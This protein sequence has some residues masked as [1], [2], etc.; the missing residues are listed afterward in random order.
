MSITGTGKWGFDY[1]RA[2][3]EVESEKSIGGKGGKTTG[4]LGFRYYVMKDLKEAKGWMG[5]KAQVL[6]FIGKKATINGQECIIGRKSFTEFVTRIDQKKPGLKLKSLDTQHCIDKLREFQKSLPQVRVSE[7][8]GSKQSSKIHTQATELANTIRTSEDPV[9]QSS[10][11]LQTVSREIQNFGEHPD[12]EHA[13]RVENALDA[14]ESREPDAV[15]HVESSPEQ[16]VSEEGE[17]VSY[18]Q[19]AKRGQVQNS[20]IEKTQARIQLIRGNDKIDWSTPRT[21]LY[22]LKQALK[23]VKPEQMRQFDKDLT[24]LGYSA[25]KKK[26]G[27]TVVDITKLQAKPKNK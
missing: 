6:M 20:E 1:H 14:A 22:G 21:T 18:A 19:A 2:Y 8:D 7:T 13:A 10:A 27:I 11:A 12:D 4:E 26:D 25:K 3:S 9:V 24:A 17:G 23:K 16:S 5:F 15:S